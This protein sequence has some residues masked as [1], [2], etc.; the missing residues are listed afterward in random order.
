MNYFR[1]VQ[2]SSQNRRIAT[3]VKDRDDID[4]ICSFGKVHAI[5]P[6]SLEP[7]GIYLGLKGSPAARVLTFVPRNRIIEFSFCRGT[8]NNLAAHR[9]PYRFFKSARTCS[10]G[11][12]EAGFFLNSSARRS[13]S[14]T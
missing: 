4:A 11:V 8:E 5:A 3:G 9:Q 12:P 10:Q 13:S 6:K 2:A 14:A 7:R 1:L